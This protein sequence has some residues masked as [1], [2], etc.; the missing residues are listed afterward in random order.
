MVRDTIVDYYT[1]SHLRYL[2]ILI[3]FSA[4]FRSLSIRERV[5]VNVLWFGSDN[6]S[7]IWSK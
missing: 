2:V 4:H 6:Q 3:T 5:C 7:T 1:L